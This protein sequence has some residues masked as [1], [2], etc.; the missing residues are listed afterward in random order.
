MGPLAPNGQ[1]K[2]VA[3]AEIGPAAAFVTNASQLE[4]TEEPPQPPAAEV[5]FEKAQTLGRKGTQG[6]GGGKSQRNQNG[7]KTAG[8]KATKPPT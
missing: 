4:S 8:A 1:T 3:K 5:L 7:P 2:A 6:K